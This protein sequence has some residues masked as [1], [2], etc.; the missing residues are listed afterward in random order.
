MWDGSS[1]SCQQPLQRRSRPH[2]RGD[3]W[4]LVNI[5]GRWCVKL[6][7][8]VRTLKATPRIKPN[9]LAPRSLPFNRVVRKDSCRGSV[10]GSDEKNGRV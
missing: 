4:V 2:Q 8:L 6:T 7:V 9:D 5:I 3:R 1:G 10:S